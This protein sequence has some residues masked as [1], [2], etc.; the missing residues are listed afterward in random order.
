MRGVSPVNNV[1]LPGY[2][3]VA[4][5]P[6]QAAVV[7]GFDYCVPRRPHRQSVHTLEA[8]WTARG[9]HRKTLGVHQTSAARRTR[10]PHLAGSTWHHAEAAGALL[11]IANISSAVAYC[12][13]SVLHLSS[14]KS[15]ANSYTREETRPSAQ[16]SL[17]LARRCSAPSQALQQSRP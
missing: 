10:P 4:H 13:A 7:S 15:G 1:H 17:R 16:I 6:R 12:P 8:Q 3:L 14:Y 5:A 2:E 11:A 9:M